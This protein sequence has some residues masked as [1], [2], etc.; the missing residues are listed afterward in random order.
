MITQIKYNKTVKRCRKLL[1]RYNSK[2]SEAESIRI[3]I[4][5]EAIAVRKFAKL[6]VFAKDLNVQYTTLMGWIDDVEKPVKEIAKKEGAKLD[7]PALNRTKKRIK[8]DTDKNEAAQIYHEE[9]QKTPEDLKLDKYVSQLKD[10]EFFICH[11][12]VLSML[13]K[14]QVETLQRYV[15][16]I[17]ETLIS[18]N[19]GFDIENKKP[20]DSQV[21]E[22]TTH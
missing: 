18:Y 12:A 7:K 1:E 21:I 3:E 2:M 17:Y 4:A 11:K 10:M 8:K 19:A 5:T 9:K 15:R 6:T 13:D 16:S 20:N 14:N 22:T